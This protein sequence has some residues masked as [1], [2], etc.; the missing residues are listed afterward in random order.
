MAVGLGID[1]LMDSWTFG[2]SPAYHDC[3]PPD[4]RI[5]GLLDSI[6]QF[7]QSKNPSV[8]SVHQSGQ[9][10]NL[11]V[12]QSVS[13]GLMGHRLPLEKGNEND[14]RQRGRLAR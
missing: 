5:L 9:S 1:E 14:Y 8:H 2:L 4:S 7:A 11:V 10:I 12:Q 3:G 13:S 6:H